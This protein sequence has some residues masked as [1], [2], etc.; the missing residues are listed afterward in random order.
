MRVGTWVRL[1]QRVR[2]GPQKA[3]ID[4]EYPTLARGAVSL[5]ERLDGFR[6]W[7]KSDLVRTTAPKGRRG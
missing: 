7:N 1:K 4:G 3:Q 5:S 6:W 2:S